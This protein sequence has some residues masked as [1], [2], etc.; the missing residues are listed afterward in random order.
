MGEHEKAKALANE[1]N[2]LIICKEKLLSAATVGAEKARYQ[3][4]EIMA[5]LSWLDFAVSHA[6]ASNFK[7]FDSCLNAGSL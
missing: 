5:L 7:A 3:S 6:I 4:E 2:S 1:Q